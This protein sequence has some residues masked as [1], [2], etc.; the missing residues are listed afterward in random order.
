M[1]AQITRH[2]NVGFKARMGHTMGH[3]ELSVFSEAGS[4]AGVPQDRTVPC[5]CSAPASFSHGLEL[6]C[7]CHSQL[8]PQRLSQAGT[9]RRCPGRRCRP[10]AVPALAPGCQ[11]STPHI[12]YNSSTATMIAVQGWRGHVLGLF[13]YFAEIMAGG[14]L[15]P[16]GAALM[17]K[18]FVCPLLNSKLTL[19]SSH[20]RGD[21]RRTVG[22]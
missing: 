7:Q 18:A 9:G 20:T 17:T 2:V 21:V 19:S 1:Q 22:A 13:L 12:L 4:L 3:A 6:P 16:Y 5:S 11:P 10:A 8:H 14:L 15:R